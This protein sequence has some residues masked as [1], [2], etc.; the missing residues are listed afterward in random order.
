MAQL[1]PI[2]SG[3]YAL[4]STLLSISYLLV[5]YTSL[6]IGNSLLTTIVA[7]RAQEADF[8]FFWIGI[9]NGAYF[10]GL[11][12]GAKYT[13]V[14]SSSVGHGRSYAV[15][16]SLGAVFILL[17]PMAEYVSVWILIRFGTG[18]CF[19]GLITLTESWLNSRA[20]RSTRGQIMSMYMITHYLS[21]GFGQLFIPFAEV[22]SFQLFSIAAIAYSLSLVPVLL[23]RLVAPPIKP[24]EKFRFREVYRYSP[25]GIFGAFV[26]GLVGS[27]LYG[28]APIY[29]KGIGLSN[30]T[31][32]FFMAVVIFSG[33]LLQ[34]PVGR[35]SDRIDRR[36]LM[37]VLSLIS[38]LASL[39]IL[40]TS[41]LHLVYFLLSAALF[42]S[43]TFTLY[44]V[45]LAYLNDSVPE[46][47]LLYAAAGMLAAFS[48]GAIVGPVISTSA[49]GIFGYSA[50]FIYIM[51]VYF[52]FA[53]LL[54]WRMRV[55]PVAPKRKKYRRFFRASGG[56]KK[57]SQSESGSEIH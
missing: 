57:T 7:L 42:G 23:T 33:V 26:C 36:K 46:E 53:L 28:L 51:C 32:A 38:G 25:T 3:I 34:W 41:S 40:L 27:A 21:A 18:Y 22:G 20:S 43:F 50:L 17:Y 1:I 48:A 4:L 9:I 10:L 13:D 30:T 56:A 11:Y 16:A 31:T 19:A 5:G 35:L 45:A 37:I 52:L 44:P 24:R 12:M 6:A 14:L 54:M 47:K 2:N 55:N 8:A 15:F 29:T 49:M 39:V